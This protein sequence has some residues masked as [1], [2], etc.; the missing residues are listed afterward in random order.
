LFAGRFLGCTL[1]L[2]IAHRASGVDALKYALPVVA[3]LQLISIPVSN[4]IS[5]TLVA[6]GASSQ[7]GVA[8]VIVES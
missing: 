3:L 5:R 1:F 2:V 6:I 7:P 8:P 4:Q